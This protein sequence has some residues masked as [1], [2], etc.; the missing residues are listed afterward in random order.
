MKNKQI[1]TGTVKRFYFKHV[2]FFPHEFKALS[3]PSSFKGHLNP[4]VMSVQAFPNA[5]FFML[6]NAVLTN[7][8]KKLLTLALNMPI[9]MVHYTFSTHQFI[10]FVNVNMR[11]YPYSN[12]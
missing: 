2:V 6:S 5:R 3:P 4:P 9:L 8:S 10:D 12:Y 1:F 11:N 7:Q